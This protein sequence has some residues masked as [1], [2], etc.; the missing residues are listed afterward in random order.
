MLERR[1]AL[2]SARPY[3]SS[4]L[5]IGK[6]RGFTLTQ[7][8]GLD[9]EFE[10][11]LASV[12]G[13]LPPKVGI[14]TES[15]GRSVM[16]IGPSEFWIIGPETDDLAAILYG[17]CTVTPLSNSRTRI[18]IKG[19]PARDVLAKGMPLDFHSA[20]FTSGMF[21]MTGLHHTPVTVHCVAENRFE[22]YVMRTFALNLWEWLNDAALEFAE[23]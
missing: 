22:L 23:R 20:V 19:S 14:V 1:S 10:K 18:F 17:K 9:A 8:A 15:A 2:A 21:A 16:R 5:Q 4:V 6:V 7:V 3:K 13:E 11:N 12:V